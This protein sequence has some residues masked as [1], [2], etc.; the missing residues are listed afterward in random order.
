VKHLLSLL[1][2]INAASIF[3]NREVNNK[4]N[5]DTIF[6]LGHQH[7]S[8]LID[9]V[10]SV[11]ELSGEQ[12]LMARET[13]LGDTLSAIAGVSSTSFGPN[14][15]R[16]VIRGLDGDRIRVLQ[17]GLGTI[18]ASSQSVDHAIPIDMLTIDQIEIVRGPMSLL[19]GAS[20]VGGV[21][22]VVTDRIHQDFDEGFFAKVN[23][24]S[25]TAQ[26]G[27]S[28]AIVLNYGINKW[29]FHL[30]IAST[31]LGEMKVPSF[32]RDKATRSAEPRTNEQEGE[33]LNSFNKQQ[34]LGLGVSRILEKG[35]IGFSY[36]NLENR[37]GTV[38]EADV[39]IDMNQNRFEL[40]FDHQINLGPFSQIKIKSAQSNYKHT[41]FEGAETGTVF[42]N[43]GNETR[44]E[45]I[46]ESDR[47]RGVSGIQFKFNDFSANGDE[48][49]LPG[50]ESRMISLF[51][52][53]DYLFGKQVLSFG[54]RGQFDEIE[55]GTTTNFGTAVK[56]DYS[57]LN[58]SLGH[59]YKFNKS[60]TLSHSFSYSQR[61]PTAQE[62]FANGPHIAS[63][64]F[65]VGS[66]NLKEEKSLAFESSFKFDTPK[67][68][69]RAS[70]FFQHFVDYV[71]LD[72]TGATDAE[73]S[74]N[75]FNYNQTDANFHGMELESDL[76]LIDF[77]QGELRT[78]STFDYVRAQATGSRGNI[79]RITPMRVGS[80]LEFREN[81]WTA[82]LGG[83]YTF[84]QERVAKAETTTGGYLLVNSHFH[85]DIPLGKHS[86]TVFGK[87][88]NIFDRE[89]RNHI[90]A[91]K[92]VTPLQ[93]RNFTLGLQGTF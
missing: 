37:Y 78:I 77:K 34:N 70:V 19:Y 21:V 65:E 85:Y 93:G 91:I 82:S 59:Q 38:A 73:S 51:S 4:H 3:A 76:H 43:E 68:K 30:D 81:R 9:F 87:L 79:A 39:T 89:A 61:A 40:H 1:L 74:L 66:Q 56:K 92:N 25:Q 90:S 75:I 35:Y 48:A 8:N 22:N 50:T 58:T 46:N 53:Q 27:A 47:F 52:V 69:G 84:K 45:L 32:A 28:Q 12:L 24:Q 2:L 88:N 80:K 72:P 55:K 6:V 5:R 62:L 29:M 64:Q 33:V 41:E 7:D 42:T 26:P 83:L 67:H 71:A 20:A 60:S 44:L 86:L 17:N 11:T 14:A 15:S 13:S 36:F 54:L 16:P 10:P 31:N 23:I 57:S 18:D 49:F 63:S